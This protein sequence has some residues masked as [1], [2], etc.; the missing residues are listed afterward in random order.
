VKTVAWS[1]VQWFHRNSFA[2]GIDRFERW[3]WWDR[4]NWDFRVAALCDTEK[5][6]DVYCDQ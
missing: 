3:Y 2:S 6:H 5:S 1:V 4:M